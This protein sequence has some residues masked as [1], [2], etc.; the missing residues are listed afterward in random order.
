MHGWVYNSR[1][2]G[3]GYRHSDSLFTNLRRQNLRL[4]S[5]VVLGHLTEDVRS[6]SFIRTD[7]FSYRDYVHVLLHHPALFHPV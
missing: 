2:R 6:A 4:P 5:V 3:F 1:K 7:P